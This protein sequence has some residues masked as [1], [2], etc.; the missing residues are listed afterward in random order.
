MSKTSMG[1][2]S[3]EVKAPVARLLGI[4]PFKNDLNI[5]GVGVIINSGRFGDGSL[6]L[7]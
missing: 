1:L 6:T 5:Y 4:S 3:G 7:G 2:L